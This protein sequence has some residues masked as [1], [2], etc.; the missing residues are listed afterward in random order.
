MS[1][2]ICKCNSDHTSASNACGSRPKCQECAQ[3]T[4]I[5]FLRVKQVLLSSYTMSR[6]FLRCRSLVDSR[7]WSTVSTFTLTAP[8]SDGAWPWCRCMI[9]TRVGKLF[10][11]WA[12]WNILLVAAGHIQQKS[13][14]SENFVHAVDLLNLYP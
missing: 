7:I 3:T 12:T 14:F 6:L 8:F 10:H 9:Y 5:R 2:R 13:T 1:S 4:M 11:P